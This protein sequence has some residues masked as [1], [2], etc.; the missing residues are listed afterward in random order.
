V[1]ASEVLTRVRDALVDAGVP[2]M[3]TGSF[4]SAAHGAP[5]AT[6]DI[7]VI[8]APTRQQ[9]RA[10]IARFP[11]SEY[12][13]SEEAADEALTRSGQFNVIDL[14]SGWKVDFIMKRPRPF[15]ETEFER[16]STIVLS[17]IEL[18]V[19][20]PEDIVIAKMEWAKL[21]G[22]GRQLEDAASVVRV[23]QDRLDAAYIERWVALLGLEDQ[24][25]LVKG[26]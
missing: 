20:S 11:K 18:D 26:A 24:W 23:Q 19:A 6:Q 8:I 25:K 17:G 2:Y 21:G 14:A 10:L 4:A 9:L 5:R 1:S 16:R 15:S 3:L 12:Y 13:V 7:D 22:S